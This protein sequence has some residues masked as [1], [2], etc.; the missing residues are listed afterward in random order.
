MPSPSIYTKESAPG[1][2]GFFLN[3]AFKDSD[4]FWR[5]FSANAKLYGI[6][7]GLDKIGHFLK[8]GRD[9][10]AEFLE[11]V[12]KGARVEDATQLAAQS[13]GVWHELHFYG[14]IASGIYSNADLAT[15]FAGL[16]F[17]RRMFSGLKID[18]VDFEPVVIRDG[19]RWVLNEKIKP[20]ELL[21]PFISAHMSEAL[22]PSW[23]TDH[24]APLI[25]DEIAKR[26]SQW[27]DAYPLI[28]SSAYADL[29]ISL[30]LWHGRDYGH[31]EQPGGAF[32][33]GR[34][35]SF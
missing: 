17:Y 11:R 27:R 35:C 22:N 34:V 1:L 28:R 19:K 6:I 13:I 8:L 30:R 4:Y 33:L 31:R 15:N 32:T 16:H 7:I 12:D 5:A 9:Y 23:Y 24:H 10:Y 20:E 26:C 18:D 14:K 2:F 29:A 3:D 25:R 21:K